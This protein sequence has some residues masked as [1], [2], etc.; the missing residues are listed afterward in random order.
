M[1]LSQNVIEIFDDLCKKIGIVIDWSAENVMPY[2]TDLFERFIK[3]ETGTSIFYITLSIFICI[4][5]GIISLSSRKLAKEVDYDEDF[6][7]SRVY[8]ISTIAAI[9]LSIAA[10]IVIGCQ[11][12]DIIQAIYLPEKTLYDFIMHQRVIY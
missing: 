12:Y 11:I 8:F 3:F 4:V 10:I 2:I 1:E 9:V 7:V 6:P 5:V